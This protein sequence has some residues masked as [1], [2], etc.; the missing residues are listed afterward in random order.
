MTGVAAL[1]AMSLPDIATAMPKTGDS[2]PGTG[3]VFDALV[4]ALVPTISDQSGGPAQA[5]PQAAPQ[6]MPP[7]PTGASDAVTTQLNV[8]DAVASLKAAFGDAMA[9]LQLQ[10]SEPP[11]S[12]AKADTVLPIPMAAVSTGLPPPQDGNVAPALPRS[13]H[14]EPPAASPPVNMDA[15]SN[16]SLAALTM[17]L[18]QV[19]P[20]GDVSPAPVNPPAQGMTIA[21]VGETAAPNPL[22][23]METIA[24]PQ[25]DALNTSAGTPTDAASP[26]AKGDTGAIPIQAAIP[27][28][29]SQAFSAV[30]PLPLKSAPSS[31]AEKPAAASIDRRGQAQ[32]I[33]GASKNI[34]SPTVVQTENAV[35][36]A[37]SSVS[38]APAD[39]TPSSS[40]GH[41][42][43]TSR[44]SQD[45][46][47]IAV[48]QLD[49]LA[50][51]AASNGY[52]SA[53][54]ANNAL[55]ELSGITAANASW[56]GA[57]Q[58]G[59]PQ[60]GAVPMNLV[61]SAA[62]VVPDPASVDALALRIAAR[63]ADGES[64]F[65]IRLDPPSLGRIEIHLNMD[66]QGNAQ[67]QLSADRPQTL[68]AL[69]RDSSALE[70]ALKD[71]GL[72]LPGGLSFSLKG[73]G[74]SAA[75]R[76]SQ[77]SGRSRAMQ[78]D[79]I[80]AANSTAAILGLTSTG[81]AWGAASIRLDIRV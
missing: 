62:G 21:N 53:T 76:D 49:N 11:S 1:P 59:A 57:P 6:A 19:A 61:L 56:A 51:P 23:A 24:V 25:K 8:P 52:V 20:A 68:D 42:E 81:Q 32:T 77:N 29:V 27:L 13:G 7:A 34:A 40:R 18:A 33:A 80:D 28:A 64:Q 66:S 22:P 45:V 4:A 54:A 16:N 50:A 43:T 36:P 75:W 60:T 37:T 65:Q 17:I 41:S 55:I 15:S 47:P 70:R 79:A 46:A 30:A 12:P 78:I 74:K 39:R 44:S 38:S 69:Q 26:P 2:A 9:A 35:P 10:A 48:P 5:A 31:T 14:S 58:T 71:A 3:S 63:S 72:D 67:A 73:D